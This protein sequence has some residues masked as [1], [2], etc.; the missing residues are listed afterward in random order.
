MAATKN[1][2]LNEEPVE[3]MI[4]ALST[5]N[6]DHEGTRAALAMESDAMTGPTV[7]GSRVGGSGPAP[8]TNS[9]GAPLALP[10]AV[11]PGLTSVTGYAVASGFIIPA[12]GNRYIAY[13]YV[14][15]RQANQYP[16]PPLGIRVAIT[17]G[18]PGCI[19]TRIYDG[20]IAN[21]RNGYLRSLSAIGLGQRTLALG[22]SIMAI[23]GDTAHNEIKRHLAEAH[24]LHMLVY[25]IRP[26]VAVAAV[27]NA[28]RAGPSAM[29]MATRP[30]GAHV[31]PPVAT[32][33]PRIHI[34][35]PASTPVR[36]E[37]IP[38]PPPA[39]M[40]PRSGMLVSLLPPRTSIIGPGPWPSNA[41]DLCA[42]FEVA[43]NV[44]IDLDHAFMT[45]NIKDVPNLR[46]WFALEVRRIRILGR[47]LNAVAHITLLTGGRPV[48]EQ[49]QNIA[50]VLHDEFE[51]WKRRTTIGLTGALRQPPED[52]RCPKRHYSWL[53]I[54]PG[55]G[56]YEKLNQAVALAQHVYAGPSTEIKPRRRYFH[57]SFETDVQAP[58]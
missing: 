12:P 3:D 38:P 35:P 21:L 39:R 53:L 57:I 18:F 42:L 10:P 54:L 9:S 36:R 6:I 23:N 1:D 50:R 29:P 26:A 51:H 41:Q 47:S 34:P 17:A 45:H 46:V 20:G 32:P 15:R 19:V 13:Q 58:S 30:P 27:V 16:I 31:P 55:K 11:Q 40:P 4:P 24:V 22:N 8:P 25:R 52:F 43:T 49:T 2:S 44:E 7:H 33:L 48:V 28:D 5:P 14:L 56:I 37:H